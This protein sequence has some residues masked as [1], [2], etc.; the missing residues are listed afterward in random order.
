MALVSMKSEEG[1]SPEPMKEN[2]YGHGLRICLNDDQC[3]ALGIMSPLPAGKVVGLRAVA[4]VTRSTE[5]V[6]MEEEGEAESEVYLDLQITDLEITAGQGGRSA[7]DLAKA[8]Y[9]D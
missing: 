1:M 9:E 3:K 4:M 7:S 2:P 8:L 6:E 5:E